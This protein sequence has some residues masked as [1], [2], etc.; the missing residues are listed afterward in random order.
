MNQSIGVATLLEDGTLVL[1][2]RAE[3]PGLG[4]ARFCYPPSDPQYAQVKAHVGEMKVG[5]S[6]SVRPFR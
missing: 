5:E 3:G 1:D 4:D 2:L 6:V